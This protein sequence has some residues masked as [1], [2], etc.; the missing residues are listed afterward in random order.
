MGC[1]PKGVPMRHRGNWVYILN[2][3]QNIWWHDSSQGQGALAAVEVGV[4]LLALHDDV[5][6]LQRQ[7]EWQSVPTAPQAKPPPV[8]STVLA[9]TA[10]SYAPTRNLHRASTS[11]TNSTKLSPHP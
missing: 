8:T 1:M 6:H 9:P 7:C 10:P 11:S 4:L 5:T 3:I 2:T